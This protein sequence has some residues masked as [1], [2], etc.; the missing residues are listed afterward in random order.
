MFVSNLPLAWPSPR[1]TNKG[2]QA[3][4][5][6]RR[7]EYTLTLLQLL[8]ISKENHRVRTYLLSDL[9]PELS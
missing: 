8:L 7:S 1:D 3:P 4:R 2:L 5:T 9:D 6:G